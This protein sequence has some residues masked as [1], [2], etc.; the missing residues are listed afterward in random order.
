[1]III[2]IVVTIITDGGHL[3]E[4]LVH[5]FEEEFVAIDRSVVE[6]IFKIR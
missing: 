4:I 6:D 3:P 5:G 1:M 2:I